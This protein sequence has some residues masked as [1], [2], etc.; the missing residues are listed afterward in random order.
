MQYEG[1][2]CMSL[3]HPTC[4]RVRQVARWAWNNSK[5][6]ITSILYLQRTIQYT[7]FLFH[8]G[9][10]TIGESVWVSI[11]SLDPPRLSL[12]SCR[13]TV[14]KSLKRRFPDEGVA[15]GVTEAVLG[16]EAEPGTVAAAGIPLVTAAQ[17]DWCRWAATSRR[18]AW[19]S[20]RVGVM[21][22][23]GAAAR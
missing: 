2:D 9:L 20:R 17:R 5:Y 1:I 7:A 16:K 12:R 8:F 23:G 18:A 13:R 14:V 11:L 10:W 22:G 4:T 21:R 15:A 3:I 19:R 6:W